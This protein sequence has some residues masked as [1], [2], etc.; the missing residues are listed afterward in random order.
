MVDHSSLVG[1]DEALTVAAAPASVWRAI[2]DNDARSSWWGYLDL[3]ATVG[4]RFEERWI[5]EDGR[6]VRTYGRVVEIIPHSLLRLSWRDEEWPEATEVEI[7]LC[8]VDAGT[9]VAVVHTGWE[10]L[11]H[12]ADLADEHLAG[13]RAHLENLRDYVENEANAAR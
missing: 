2:V 4:G 10:R 8:E 13:W 11:P 3:E 7:R 1:V 9:S 5:D 12:G 6:P